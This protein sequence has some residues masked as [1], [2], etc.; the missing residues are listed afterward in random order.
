MKQKLSKIKT[1][2]CVFVEA[3]ATKSFFNQNKNLKI[4]KH[5]N[6]NQMGNDI[7]VLS[8]SHLAKQCLPYF[9]AAVRE[10]EGVKDENDSGERSRTE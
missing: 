10:T 8:S 6:D 7:S 5:T 4:L 9:A 1:I 3:L 2:H